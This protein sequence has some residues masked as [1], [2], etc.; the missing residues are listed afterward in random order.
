ML[1]SLGH[2]LVGLLIG[3]MTTLL[4]A[5]WFE[6]SQGMEHYR[7]ADLLLVPVEE[8]FPPALPEE[9]RLFGEDRSLASLY[10][11]AR[12]Y[13]SGGSAKRDASYGLA[14][15][16][17]Q[18]KEDCDRAKDFLEEFVQLGGNRK[19]VSEA[20]ALAGHDTCPSKAVLEELGF[21]V[22]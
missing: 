12:A 7:L 22:Q 21:A 17:L 20:I 9:A 2:F 3:V 19:A 4:Y 10:H 18:Q 14:V 11:L 13:Q 15:W 1:R 5:E 8:S 6:R 16:F